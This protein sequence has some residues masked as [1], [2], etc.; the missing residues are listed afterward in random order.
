MD[1]FIGDDLYRRKNLIKYFDSLILY[2]LRKLKPKTEIENMILQEPKKLEKAISRYIKLYNEEDTPNF[3]NYRYKNAV[4]FHHYLFE[5]SKVSLANYEDTIFV[6][7]K[8]F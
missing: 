3:L 8:F 4:L 7:N 1:D 6:C 2:E 5:Q